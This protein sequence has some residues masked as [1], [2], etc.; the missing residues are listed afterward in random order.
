MHSNRDGK[1][2]PT[3]ATRACSA[4]IERFQSAGMPKDIS[5]QPQLPNV[6]LT[7]LMQAEII[8]SRRGR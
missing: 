4:Q 3:I 2:S 5:R 8:A 1:R 7:L 6:V